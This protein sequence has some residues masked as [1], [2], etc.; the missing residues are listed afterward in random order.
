M[1]A[2]NYSTAR[3]NFKKFCDTAVQD[4][5]TIIV[6]RKM[7]ENVVLMSESEYNNL[8]E[9][10]YIRSDKADYQCLL[11]SVAQL[12]QGKGQIRTLIDDE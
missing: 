11:E 12:K 9:N 5:E 1:I 4:F 10:L 7:G 6:T 2:V 8:M 3:D